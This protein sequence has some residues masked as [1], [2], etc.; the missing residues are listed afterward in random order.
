MKRIA[1]FA[2]VIGLALAGC[3]P[4][5]TVTTADGQQGVAKI[6]RIPK[7]GENKVQFRM[8]DAVNALRSAAGAAP[9]KLNAQL[10]A[11]AKTHARDMSVQ[12]RPWHFGSDGSSPLDRVARTGYPLTMRGEAISETFETELETLAAWMEEKGTRD[13][14]L[15]PL[16]QDL[17]F[18]YLQE[19]N[20]KLWW[21]LLMGGPVGQGVPQAA[22][23]TP[24][25]APTPQGSV[26]VTSSATAVD[27]TIPILPGGPQG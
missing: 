8:L 12:N 16:S 9:V 10:N 15:D 7:N 14:I 24:T 2:T 26:P 13:I 18:G 22:N 21:T 20:G 17:G 5:T 11:A 25:P 23:P 3:T 1:A 27:A 6:Y 4:T 19:S